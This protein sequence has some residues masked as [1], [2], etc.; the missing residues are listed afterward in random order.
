MPAPGNQRLTTLM[1]LAA[2]AVPLV[3]FG[4]QLI[5]A[6]WYP[7]YRFATDTASMLGTTASL[8]PAIFNDGAMLVGIAGFFGAAGLFLGLSNM[9]GLWLRILIAVGVVCNGVLSLKAGLFPM[10]DPRHASWQ[11]LLFPIL[12][13]PLLLLAATWRTS[14][15]LRIYLVADVVCLLLTIPMMMHRMAPLWPEGTMQ[16]LFAVLVMVPIGV[17]A[18]ALMR[19][20]S[21]P[22][23]RADRLRTGGNF[24][25]A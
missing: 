6:P 21:H 2:V 18:L 16:R 23:L 11:F 19:Q 10:P 20:N 1:L 22:S 5:A 12:I 13:T 25:V 4:V 3:Y 8:H 9:T 15:W 7:G 24:K 17:V 14:S